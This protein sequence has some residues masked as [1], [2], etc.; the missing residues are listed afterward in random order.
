MAVTFIWQDISSGLAIPGEA[1]DLGSVA[2]GSDSLSLGMLGHYETD[3]SV[4]I[5]T[6]VGFYISPY[7]GLYTGDFSAHKDYYDLLA[8]GDIH[9][10]STNN[11]GFL[12]NQRGYELPE[13]PVTVDITGESVPVGETSFTLGEV[14]PSSGQ[15]PLHGPYPWDGA[16]TYV[17]GNKVLH[18][19]V[20]YECILGH[21]N[22]EPP[23]GTYWAVIPN[24]G[25]VFSDTGVFTTE[26]NWTDTL[27]A[28]GEYKI[29][30]DTGEVET[31][32]TTNGGTVDYTV[33]GTVSCHSE[34]GSNPDNAIQLLKTACEPNAANDGELPLGSVTKMEVGISLPSLTRE[35]GVRQISMYLT[36]SYTI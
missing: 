3:I 12:I 20:L 22:E 25:V 18:I 23:N 4:V 11:R 27:S 8:F 2:A 34:R 19:G 16:I 32:S 21:T 24:E 1:Q 5:L 15:L 31:F 35:T 36:F 28:P 26:K 29:N 7:D 9:R 6:D 14:F 30:Y 33:A 17:I 13:F 10:G